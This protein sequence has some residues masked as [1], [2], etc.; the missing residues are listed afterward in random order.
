MM[1]GTAA[2]VSFVPRTIAMAAAIAS[3]APLPP[4]RQGHV[5]PPLSHFAF[6]ACASSSDLASHP[7]VQLPL[8]G[9]ACRC[10]GVLC[11]L[12][13]RYDRI[14]SD[15]ESSRLV[16]PPLIGWGLI[17]LVAWLLGWVAEK[18][19]LCLYGLPNGRWEVAL[20]SEE[21]PPEMPEPTVG[22]NFARDGMKRRDWLSLVVVHS[23]S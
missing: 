20:P 10:G 17:G 5:L 23:D 21:V 14:G 1:M 3:S 9:C 12:R 15:L 16:M 11:L 13:P 4:V 7:A 18:E 8:L 19:N 6:L 2:P 22:I